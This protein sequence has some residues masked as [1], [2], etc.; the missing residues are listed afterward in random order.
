MKQHLNIFTSIVHLQLQPHS[1]CIFSLLF[2]F[3]CSIFFDYEW[4]QAGM[5]I[6]SSSYIKMSTPWFAFMAFVF[7]FY[8]FSINFF[9]YTIYIHIHPLQ[10]IKI[11]HFSHPVYFSI[12][13]YFYIIFFACLLFKWGWKIAGRLDQI[14]MP[15]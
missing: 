12:F 13:Y 15:E 8:Y 9:I 4:N 2:C 5:D 6:I 10:N 3:L 11:I 7:Y 1:L 14:F